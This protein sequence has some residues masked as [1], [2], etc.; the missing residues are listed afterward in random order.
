MIC[1]SCYQLIEFYWQEDL[2]WQLKKNFEEIYFDEV[3]VMAKFKTPLNQLI[4]ALKYKQHS[5]AAKFLGQM[6]FFHLNL[7]F[8]SF[9]LITFVPI[10][11]RKIKARGYN[12]AELIAQELGLWSQI[13]VKNVLLRT[14]NTKAQASVKNK[15]E[16]L[17]RLK[18]VFVIK[19]A[20]QSQLKDKKI[21]LIDDV[22][23]TG[24][25]SNSVSQELKKA[26]VDWI[27]VLAVASKF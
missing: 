11:Q 26:G 3:R 15:A 10:H 16:R 1:S 13:P 14:K 18:Q 25:T 5:R 19:N 8:K 2:T 24:A 17:A 12:Q 6:L 20:W 22:I 4:K 21:L 7:D 23:T 27:T 9:D